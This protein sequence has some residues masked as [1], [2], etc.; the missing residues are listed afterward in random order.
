MRWLTSG[1]DVRCGEGRSGAK[2][3]GYM[4]GCDIDNASK[5]AGYVDGGALGIEEPG[6]Q[7]LLWPKKN[8]A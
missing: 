8:F 3:G 6:S 1:R 2:A 5:R 7:L 4:V